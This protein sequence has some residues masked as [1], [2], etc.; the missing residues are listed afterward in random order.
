MHIHRFFAP[1]LVLAA[2]IGLSTACVGASVPGTFRIDATVPEEYN[3]EK[4]VVYGFD[5]G[6]IAA[7]KVADGKFTIEG[8]VREIQR[9]VLT[10][11]KLRAEFVLEPA[12]Y[13]ASRAVTGLR[14]DGGEYN[15]QV[16][17]YLKLPE[18]IAAVTELKQF[19]D[20]AFKD[21]DQKPEAE[22]NRIREENARRN[23]E[24]FRMKDEYQ[25]K[26]LSGNGPTLLK[27]LVL[28]NSEDWERYPNQKRLQ[29]LE[30]YEKELGVT[31]LSTEIRA[32]LNDQIKTQQI[33][34]SLT[35]GHEYV[36]VTVQDYSGKSA[37]LSQALARNKLVLLDFW[38]S[39]C[40]P[41]RAEFPYL[42]QVYERY[43]DQGFEI[44]SVSLDTSK[45]ALLKALDEEKLPWA[46]YCD[47]KGSEGAA[48]RA[49]AVQGLPASF[50]I[51]S[52]GRIVG[53]DLRQQELEKAVRENI[54][55]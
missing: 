54:D 46:T 52:G 29:M 41:C 53:V 9:A 42:K 40:S 20:E 50:L 5:G 35:P 13:Q 25:D 43:H 48:P 31:P 30:Q 4:A 6:E 34:A 26:I 45:S 11:G 39:W 14:V 16:F 3:G 18:V 24:L 15:D 7:S 47:L 23:Q 38:A 28:S 1:L 44:Y 12:R 51:A 33:Q 2:I 21:I 17:G 49:Y 8:T 10:V 32:A 37:T 19:Q 55:P 22:A 36:D 27:L